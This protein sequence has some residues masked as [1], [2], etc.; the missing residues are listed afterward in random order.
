MKLIAI[1]VAV[2]I[3][4][5]QAL[6]EVYEWTDDRGSV[7]FTDTLDKVPQKYR[8]NVRKRNV[9]EQPNIMIINDDASFAVDS[10]SPADGG[11]FQPGGRDESWWRSS[12]EGL[13]SEISLIE[14]RL[15]EE[16]QRLLE[17][18]RR[19]TLYQKPSDRGAYN[20]LKEKIEKDEVRIKELKKKLEALE[21]DA[22]RGGVPPG[23]RQ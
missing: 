21:Q 16:R 1:V 4:S 10:A 9:S 7:G 18:N 19:R 17:I 2:C 11:R 8:K 14:D 12:F 23:W 3:L 22:D 13:R 5:S 20:A 6:A 15:P